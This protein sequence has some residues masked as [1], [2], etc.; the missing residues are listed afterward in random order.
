[1]DKARA[2]MAGLIGAEPDEIVFTRGGSEASN[3]AI[4]G[5]AFASLSG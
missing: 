4:K 2:Q 3:L 5:V 1:M